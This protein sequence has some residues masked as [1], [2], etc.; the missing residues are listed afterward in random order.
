MLKE[1]EEKRL[2]DEE[3]AKKKSEEDAILRIAQEKE[4]AQK[5]QMEEEQQKGVLDAWFAQQQKMKDKNRA[6]YDLILAHE[7]ECYMMYFN[8]IA[9][10][11]N[12]TYDLWQVF[13]INQFLFCFNF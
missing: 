12:E 9:D 7:H 4:E 8:D 10:E 5:K 1:N 3:E 13:C 6:E 11:I 2:I